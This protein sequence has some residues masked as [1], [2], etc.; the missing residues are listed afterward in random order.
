MLGGLSESG[1]WLVASGS[2]EITPRSR[3]PLAANG[4]PTKRWKRIA[5]PLEINALLI[6]DPAGPILIA[7]FDLLYA[8]NRIRQRVEE[9][10]AA[11]LKPERILLT[12]SHTHRAPAV[13]GTKPRLGE[14]DPDYDDLV[15]DALV[16][17]VQDLLDREPS[18]CTL[19]ES[20]GKCHAGINRRR[21]GRAQLNRNG[22]EPAGMKMAPNP[23]GPVDRTLRRADFIKEEGEIVATLWSLA[24]HPTAFPD[25]Y[26][27][28]SDFIGVARSTLRK[29]QQR[30]ILFFQ[31]FSGD[32]RPPAES[33]W[34]HH[35]IQRLL[36]GPSFSEFRPPQYRKW[37][38]GIAD[39]VAH[40]GSGQFEEA[41]GNYSKVV[42]RRIE[43]SRDDF[44]MD[45]TDQTPVSFH[46]VDL[47]DLQLVAVGGE[48]TT[49]YIE[50]LKSEGA[51]PNVWPIGC[52]DHVFGYAATEKQLREGGYE[53][54]GFCSAFGAGG[55]NAEIEQS[56]RRGFRILFEK[57]P[58]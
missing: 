25:R 47:G 6:H 31:G 23:D 1:D 45:P 18:R 35:P 40:Q 49:E 15:Q 16:D 51:S 42:A 55:V 28:S 2:V 54:G 13:D 39:A 10:F 22:I 32:V 46:R 53:A 36:I 57:E 38:Q 41:A 3:Q 30:P 43:R 8:S 19:V 37:S 11:I 34:R 33:S 20:R 27:V 56:V 7:T 9:H 29:E 44:L 14:A 17:L 12:A 4:A 58:V 21:L 5:D 52:A 24:C 50:I 48:L 26:A